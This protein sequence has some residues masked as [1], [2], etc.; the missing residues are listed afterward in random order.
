VPVATECLCSNVKSGLYTALLCAACS[1]LGSL[2]SDP[3]K[4]FTVGLKANEEIM[5]MYPGHK[6]VA[7][8]GHGKC[9][10]LCWHEY[11]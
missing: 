7:I 1:E 2:H 5:V 11:M 3:P 6:V 10:S 4:S 9:I 8:V